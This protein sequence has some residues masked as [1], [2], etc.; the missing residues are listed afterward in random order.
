[1]YKKTTA[2][3]LSL[4][5]LLSIGTGALMAQEDILEEGQPEKVLAENITLVDQAASAQ[6]VIAYQQSRMML[7]KQWYTY[8]FEVAPRPVGN[9]LYSVNTRQ[10]E[11]ALTLVDFPLEQ[12]GDYTI[13]FLDY[14]LKDYPG[15]SAYSFLD[16]SAVVFAASYPMSVTR[17]HQ[18]AVHELGHQVDFQLMTPQKWTEYMQIRGLNNGEF[19]NYSAYHNRRPQEIFA[20]DFRMLF[21]G[22]EAKKISHLNRTL[23]PVEE[24]PGLKAFFQS[25]V[26]NNL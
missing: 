3:L 19:S 8:T 15:V 25:L 5:L 13:Y 18:L 21:G 24:F 14:K 20:D 17:T 10:Y 23:P 16:D 4:A 9:T 11:E 6:Q 2:W 26:N 12:V 1:M 7:T 22:E